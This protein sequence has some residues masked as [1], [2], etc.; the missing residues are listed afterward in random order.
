MRVIQKITFLYVRPNTCFINEKKLQQYSPTAAIRAIAPFK[1][2]IIIVVW[3]RFTATLSPQK[4]IS[5]P[6]FIHLLI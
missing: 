4:S 2:K 1:E 5:S 6:Y 3:V